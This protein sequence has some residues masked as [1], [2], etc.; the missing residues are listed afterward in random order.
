MVIL[1]Q[2][3]CE[4]RTFR[5]SQQPQGIPTGGTRFIPTAKLQNLNQKHFIF[6]FFLFLACNAK[7]TAGD[8]VQHSK[9][10]SLK[11]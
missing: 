6:L 8:V 3:R 9:A 11:S 2:S 4:D 5:K 7:A 10:F 1:L